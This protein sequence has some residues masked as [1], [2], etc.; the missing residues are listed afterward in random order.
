[1]NLE[2]NSFNENFVKDARAAKFTDEQIKFLSE[3]F[4][5]HSDLDECLEYD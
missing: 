5:F 3:W 1:M 2:V 4:A